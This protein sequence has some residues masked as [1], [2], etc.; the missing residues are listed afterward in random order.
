M[1]LLRL[2]L[3]SAWLLGAGPGLSA[4]GPGSG[5]ERGGTGVA[6]AEAP[7]PANATAARGARAKPRTPVP[8]PGIAPP[9]RLEEIRIE[10][11]IPAPQVLFVTARG[12]RHLVRFHHRRYLPSSVQVGQAATLPT[13]LAVS[14]AVSVPPGAP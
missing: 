11:E 12:Q 8:A 5:S 9:R 3:A 4:A 6:A 1:T 10:G 7:R 13:R 14:S 2:L